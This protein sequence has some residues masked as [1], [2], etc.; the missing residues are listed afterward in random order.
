MVLNPLERKA[1]GCRLAI[2][3]YEATMDSGAFCV[4]TK[5]L[6]IVLDSNEVNEF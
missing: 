3:T 4:N 5:H 1:A 2:Y 6:K